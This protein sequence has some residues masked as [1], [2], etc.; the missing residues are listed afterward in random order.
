MEVE[1]MKKVL[2]IFLA[3]V[4]L[5]S[6]VVFASAKS[7]TTLQFDENGHFKILVLA[8]IQSGFPVGE[9]LKAYIAEAIDA[10]DPNL[11]VFLGDN[12]MSAEDGTVES[13]WKGYDEVFPILESKGVPFTFVFGNHDDES[14]PTVTKEE[15]LK[16][17]QSYDGCLAYDADPSLHGCATHNLPI[18][19]SDGNNVVYN[20]WFFD[21]G[22]YVYNEQTSRKGYDCVRRDQ[23]EWYEAESAKLK[24]ANGGEVV[25]SLAFEHIIP[26][27]A[28]QAVMF[29]LPFQL[30]KITRNFSDG[31]SATYLPNYFAFD[32]ILSEAPCP[33]ADN[34]GQWDSFVETGDVKACFF[35][36]DHVN[37][38]SVNVDG[39]DAVSVPGTTF[40]SYSS[41]TDQGSMVITLDERDL[42]TYSTE[43][44]YT[45]DLAVK[46]GSNIPNQEHSE[47]VTAYKFRTVLRYLAHGI[48]TVLRGIYAYIP[49]ILVK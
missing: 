42:S 47:T 24:A 25:P 38:F 10:S 39:V 21:S 26:Q 22:D 9:A 34:E 12:I 32:G 28:T 37:N 7:D 33:S 30:G 17:Y 41:I 49:S 6:G 18:L 4:I 14:A 35:G 15:M 13:Y 40:K 36:H 23:I 46:E 11:V 31:T 3:V 44:L 45:S 2:S 48:L 1:T 19:S 8:D 29:S 27:E 5:V 16:K 20:L 43:I